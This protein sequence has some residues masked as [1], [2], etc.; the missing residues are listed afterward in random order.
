MLPR[1]SLRL[2]TQ[3]R[4]E[5]NY[6][7][8]LARLT[9]CRRSTECGRMALRDVQ[10]VAGRQTKTRRTGRLLLRCAR[11]H[12]MLRCQHIRT[13]T[14]RCTLSKIRGQSRTHVS[15]ADS[16]CVIFSQI[17]KRV[18]RVPSARVVRDFSKINIFQK[19][20]RDAR[21]EEGAMWYIAKCPLV[22]ILYSNTRACM[23]RTALDKFQSER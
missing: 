20:E 19:L 16:F 5:R 13:P 9:L 18:T 22:Y 8:R 6:P 2:S 1:V 23:T 14:A 4:A 15:P 11:S 17:L 3:P 7:T 10:G 12:Q 21:S